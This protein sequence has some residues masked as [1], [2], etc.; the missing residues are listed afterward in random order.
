LSIVPLTE[1]ALKKKHSSSGRKKVSLI[2]PWRQ[3]D[4]IG[5]IFAYWAID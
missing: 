5:R 4:Q 3:G 1:D 2:L